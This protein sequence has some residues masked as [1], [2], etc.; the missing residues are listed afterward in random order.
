M[1]NPGRRRRRLPPQRVYLHDEAVSK[2]VDGRTMP[3]EI[4]PDRWSPAPMEDQASMLFEHRHLPCGIM[5][6]SW[7][8]ASSVATGPIARGTGW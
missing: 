2:H 5:D 4:R 3:N 1:N 8:L 7:S 6:F